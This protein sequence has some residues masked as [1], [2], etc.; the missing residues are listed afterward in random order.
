MPAGLGPESPL[1]NL[2][3]VLCDL[4]AYKGYRSERLQ[5]FD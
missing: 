5:G 4:V 2:L 3:T 1:G